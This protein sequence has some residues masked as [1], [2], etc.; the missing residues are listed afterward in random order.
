MPFVLLALTLGLGGSA[1]AV[2]G[3]G[4][5]QGTEHYQWMNGGTGTERTHRLPGG[6]VVVKQHRGRL[7]GVRELKIDVQQVTGPNRMRVRHFAATAPDAGRARLSRPDARELDALI[8][9]MSVPS[10]AP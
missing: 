5:A 4:R 6:T 9:A 10:A 1:G 7:P 8:G 2:K 3:L